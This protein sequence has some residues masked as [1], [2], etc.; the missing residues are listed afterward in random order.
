MFKVFRKEM[1]W[2]GRKLVIETG[3][4]ARQAD[5]AVMVSYGDTVVLCTAVG[6]KSPKP[7][8]DFFPLTV[9][10]Q[11][12]AFA[13]GKIPGGFFKR[14]GRPTEKEVLVSRL[15]DRPIRPLFVDG[16]RCETQVVCTVL[17]HDLENDPD[18][19]AM[20]G[21]SAALTISGLPFLGP[22][23]AARV[24]Y[25]SGQF[26]LNP[27]AD[28]VE[29]ATLD[30][31]VAGTQEG[32]LMVESEAKEL[33]EEIMLGAVMFG[34]A[35]FQPVI[36]LII[37]LAEDAAKEPRD[38]APPA[39]DKAAVKARIL[40][41]A[42]ADV[43]AA[44]SILV[45][46][47]RYAAVGA[48]KD[49]AKTELKDEFAPEAISEMFKEVEADVLRGAVLD[50]GKR[51]DGRTT[52]DIRPIVA[53]VGILPRAHGSA[54]FTRG[55]T[56]ALVVAT[57]GTNQDEQIIDALEGEYRESFMLHYNFPPYSV[58]EAGRMGSPGRRE[59][60]H[61]K[62][63]WRAIHPLLP[64]KEDFPYTLRVV[65]EITESNGSSSMA[66]V[67]GTSLSLMDAG[68]PLARP[69][70]GIAMGLIKEGEKFA[71]LSDILGDEDHLGD[72]D[73]KVAGTEAGVTA[74]Q[75]DI[76]IT[77]ITE[78]IMKVALA[79]AQKGRIHILGEMN[80]ALNTARG[81]VSG[82]APRITVINIPKEKIRDVIGSGGKVIREIVEQTGAKID[83][84]DDG[85]VKVSAVDSKCSDAAIKWIKGI[86]AEPEVGEVYDGKVVKV[87]DFG[88]FVNFLGSRDG[89]VHISELKNERVAKVTDVVKQGDAVKVKVLGFDDRG[90]VKLSMKVV[91]QVTGE[92]LS[93]KA[94]A[95]EG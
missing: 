80:K 54:L 56:Q 79:Q 17:S 63:A 22:I 51:I 14:E 49:K 67:C 65:S 72:M 24:G 38:I 29:N 8:V 36:D 83:I 3:K 37:S 39:F 93:K 20:I 86:V 16:Y 35:Q 19:V 32:V 69:I 45:K 62:L 48:A 27:T 75:M 88:A 11:E 68:A 33:S 28:Q 34:H 12:K 4:I 7:G 85:T 60:G 15:I 55:E 21:A 5:G 2:G 92:D 76:K 59:I 9:N 70:A 26:I 64:S 1:E 74:L 42:G 50:T 82:N 6:A 23:G 44:Y 25:E 90:K 61:G 91:D 95:A 52:V 89:L 77:S 81:E 41:V 57:L 13:A 71:V 87:M 18:I 73:F 53:E 40:E 58:G 46:Q 47:D 66:T 78:E 31:V 94:E 10:Y 84:E 30:L 43:K